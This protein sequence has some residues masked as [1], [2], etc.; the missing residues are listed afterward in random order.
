M[1]DLTKK[2]TYKHTSPSVRI[3]DRDRTPI[4][5]LSMHNLIP[6]A[7]TNDE[8]TLKTNVT[9]RPLIN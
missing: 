2:K 4:D 5:H 6:K 8:L 7:I 1:K 9:M 3:Q